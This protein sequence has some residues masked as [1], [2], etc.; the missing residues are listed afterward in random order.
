MKLRWSW[1]CGLAL[2]ELNE[3]QAIVRGPLV[4]ARDSRFKDGDG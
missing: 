1:I 4:L 3:A 2:V